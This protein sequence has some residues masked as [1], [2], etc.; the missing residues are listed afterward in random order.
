MAA[1]TIPDTAFRLRW[2]QTWPDHPDDFTARA[3]GGYCRVYRMTGGPQDGRWFWV[4]ARSRTLGTD[5]ADTARE[6]AIKAD[7]AEHFPSEGV[8]AR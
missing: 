7:G 1:S 8:A 3:D 6:A 4:A 5:F 2:R